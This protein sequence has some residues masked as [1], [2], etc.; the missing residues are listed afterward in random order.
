[1]TCGYSTTTP[2]GTFTVYNQLLDKCSATKFC[3]KKGHILAPILTNE[4]KAAV[5]K[6]IDPLCDIHQGVRHYHLGLD[7]TPCGNA[8][9]RVFSN[10][11]KY[12]KDV[13][14]HL[15][16]DYNTPATKCPLAYISYLYGPIRLVI[17]TKNNCEQEPM[18][19]ICL[20]QS[21]ATA[22]GI[23]KNEDDYYKVSSKKALVA[24][25]GAFIAFGCLAMVTLRFYRQNNLLKKELNKQIEN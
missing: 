20:D 10:G 15:Y 4:D 6:L 17:G 1:M 8:Q 23:T 2:S 11:V 12:N 3:K 14:G 7:I 5:R 16:I 22:S 18:K 13:H 9:D 21:T 24:V 19:F 25:G